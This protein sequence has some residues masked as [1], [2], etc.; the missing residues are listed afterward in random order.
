MIVIIHTIDG[1][2]NPYVVPFESLID[3]RQYIQAH[4]FITAQHRGS[5]IEALINTRHI[6]EVTEISDSQPSRLVE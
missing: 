2:R 6:L 4:R 3:L 1:V 5:K